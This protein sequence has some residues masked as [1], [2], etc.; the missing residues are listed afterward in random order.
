MSTLL[1]SKKDFLVSSFLAELSSE[2]RFWIR[3]HCAIFGII[4]YPKKLFHS[5]TD[6]SHWVRSNKQC[7]KSSQVVTTQLQ[8]RELIFCNLPVLTKLNEW[9]IRK[10]TYTS[11]NQTG[12]INTGSQWDICT[13]E[14]TFPEIWQCV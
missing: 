14:D 13:K 6:A 7:K 11:F 10:T 1:R 8:W 3:H 12:T 9:C 5:C 2:C 4:T